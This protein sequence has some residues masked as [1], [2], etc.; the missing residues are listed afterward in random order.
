MDVIIII[1]SWIFFLIL[2]FVIGVQVKD[3]IDE[4]RIGKS[5]DIGYKQG[6]V[7]GYLEGFEDG[8]KNTEENVHDAC[9]EMVKKS[10]L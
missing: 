9:L 8:K 1:A 2:G 7:S 4:K 6:R 3:C 10:I 5:F